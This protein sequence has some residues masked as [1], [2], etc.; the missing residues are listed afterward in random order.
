MIHKHNIAEL[1]LVDRPVA[2]PLSGFGSVV[3]QHEAG[4]NAC[5][6]ETT[7]GNSFGYNPQPNATET[8]K[9]FSYTQQQQSG[10][11]KPRPFEQ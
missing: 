3:N 8:I 10:L 5:Y 9:N 2:G 1:S 4:H 11:S 7:S 6:R